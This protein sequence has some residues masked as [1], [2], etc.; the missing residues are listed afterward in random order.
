MYPRR[1]LL[2]GLIFS[3]SLTAIA[4]AGE[5]SATPDVEQVVLADL[6]RI[7]FYEVAPRSVAAS[8]RK[9]A[10][11]ACRAHGQRKASERDPGDV[12]KAAWLCSGSPLVFLR[13]VNVMGYKLQMGYVCDA[14]A[15]LSAGM[16]FYMSDLFTDD[17]PCVS[18][19]YDGETKK[20]S[21][22][23]NDVP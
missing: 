13:A 3:W 10:K 16:K 19:S 21:L 1:S 4:A 9:A 14:A 2:C 8:M 5:S 7:A 11:Q 17:A 18:I 23:L 6:I 20:H 22:D 12:A 15:F